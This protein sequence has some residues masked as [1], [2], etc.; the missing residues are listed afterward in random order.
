MAIVTEIT[1][2]ECQEIAN[3]ADR[4][5]PRRRLVYAQ[6]A[7]LRKLTRDDVNRA[8]N[9]YLDPATIVIAVGGPM[10]IIQENA[11]AEERAL[12]GAR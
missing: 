1:A 6:L 2:G 4:R 9:R 10:K 8:A 12:V 11:A 7:A 3:S 5:H